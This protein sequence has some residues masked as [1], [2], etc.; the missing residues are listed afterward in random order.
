M[1]MMGEDDASADSAAAEAPTVAP[2]AD[3]PPVAATSS[4]CWVSH[5][6]PDDVF[7]Q[8][9]NGVAGQVTAGGLGLNLAGM[10]ASTTEEQAALIRQCA[11]DG[12]A[13]MPPRWP[14]LTGCARPS[15]THRRRV[16]S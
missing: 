16:R 5:G 1:D 2:D 6:T 11:D 7:W 4:L 10:N 14:T 12:V 13:V 8:S 9:A 15:P 3:F